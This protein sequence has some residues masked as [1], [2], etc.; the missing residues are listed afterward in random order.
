M[1]SAG[2]LPMRPLPA[3]A[4]Q[5]ARAVPSWPAGLRDAAWGRQG[6]GL[7][8]LGLR[9]AFRIIRRPQRPPSLP[10]PPPLAGSGWVST[11]PC[12]SVP[13]RRPCPRAAPLGVAGLAGARLR[14][15]CSSLQLLQGLP[16]AHNTNRVEVVSG[17]WTEPFPETE[18]RQ[19]CLPRSLAPTLLSP[20]QTLRCGTPLRADRIPTSSPPCSAPQRG[21]RAAGSSSPCPAAALRSAPPLLWPRMAKGLLYCSW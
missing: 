5:R 12:R 16:Y 18:R 15:G 9:R 4:C 20:L 14:G 21:A 19:K 13:R 7:C 10:P 17:A 11:G 8:V 1:G 2:V 3:P 6:L